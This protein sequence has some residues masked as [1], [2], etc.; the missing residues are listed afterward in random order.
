M[1]NNSLKILLHVPVR[2]VFRNIHFY[3]NNSNVGNNLTYFI[4]CS[5]GIAVLFGVSYINQQSVINSFISN[6]AKNKFN[7]CA[8]SVGDR[9]SPASPRTSFNFLADVVEKTQKSVVYIEINA[10]HPFTGKQIPISNGSGFIVK[11]DGL[12]LTNAHVVN[13]FGQVVVKLYNGKE[14][15]GIVE[16][17]DTES[18]LATVRIQATNLPELPLGC[19]SN[20]R[21]GEFV[22]AMGNP[23]T[24]SHTITAGVV[25]SANRQGEELGL[26]KKSDYIQTDAAIN[27]GNS[28]GPLVNLD[29]EAIGINTMKVTEGISFAIPSDRATEFLKRSEKKTKTG[30]WNIFKK[31]SEKTRHKFLGITMLT[32]STTVIKDLKER[33]PD[34]P[35]VDHGVL[36]WRVMV[37]SPSYEC[38]IRPGDVITKVNHHKVKSASTI[39]NCLEKEDVL[40]LTVQRGQRTFEI[41]VPLVEPIMP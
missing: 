21:P 8:F 39:Q 17:I 20:L 10:R 18:D 7:V 36:V 13:H 37:G 30:Q 1:Q 24:L 34:F 32:L 41:D 15:P 29:G 16:D 38:G 31:T 35:A 22:I 11:E 23:L 40:K 12:I 26:H 2:N 9:K 19:S 25:S 33:N 3:R 5:V 6:L 27:V 14:Y 28:G 4:G